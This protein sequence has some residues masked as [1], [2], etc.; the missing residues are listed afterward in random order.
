M[1]NQ[2]N[3]KII[4]EVK[5]CYGTN[6]VKIVSEHKDAINTLTG[7]KTLSQSDISALKALGFSFEVQ[8]AEVKV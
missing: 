8:H 3:P 6:W 5:P 1:F 7:N 4:V 2:M